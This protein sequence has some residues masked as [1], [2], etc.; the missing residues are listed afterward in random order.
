[1]SGAKATSSFITRAITEHDFQTMDTVLYQEINNFFTQVEA[2]GTFTPTSN[3]FAN[4][5]LS[6]I[7]Q[8]T[9]GFVSKGSAGYWAKLCTVSD[10]TREHLRFRVQTRF[11]TAYR[12]QTKEG[13]RGDWERVNAEKTLIQ[14]IASKLDL[15]LPYNIEEVP[16]CPDGDKIHITMDDP[17]VN[18][19][20]AV[21]LKHLMGDSIYVVQAPSDTGSLA[22]PSLIQSNSERPSFLSMSYPSDATPAKRH[23]KGAF[24]FKP[25]TMIPGTYGYVTARSPF[26]DRDATLKM[27]MRIFSKDYVCTRVTMLFE[28]IASGP[29]HRGPVTK[30]RDAQISIS[31]VQISITHQERAIHQEA[32]ETEMARVT[33]N[34]MRKAFPSMDRSLAYALS[35]E[36]TDYMEFK[37]DNL[38][39]LYDLFKFCSG[40]EDIQRRFGEFVKSISEAKSAEATERAISIRSMRQ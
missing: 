34:N 10:A 1:M 8:K 9:V 28:L 30:A 38:S 11:G 36:S 25:G 29:R 33:Y 35:T 37:D 16:L 27:W 20:L 6:S 39:P 5:I 19:V 31:P 4:E 24:A 22:P 14:T 17:D 2:T 3:P 15:P 26:S 21:I 7:Y 23:I 18:F 32:F 13:S 40:N 12:L